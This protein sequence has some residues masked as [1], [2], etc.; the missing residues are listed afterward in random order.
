MA[1]ICKH[2]ANLIPD[3]GSLIET[4]ESN[5]GAAPRKYKLDGGQLLTVTQMKQSPANVNR[6]SERT[7]RR[8][9]DNGVRS[10]KELFAQQ[11]E[12]AVKVALARRVVACQ[13]SRHV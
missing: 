4:P 6:L 8:R 5:R 9:L 3:T 7:I 13:T 2:W 11:Q 1:M 10:P 12:D